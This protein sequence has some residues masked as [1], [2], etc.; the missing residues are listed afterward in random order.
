MADVEQFSIGSQ[1]QFSIGYQ[2]QFPLLQNACEDLEKSYSLGQ[3]LGEGQFGTTYLCTELATGLQYACKRIPKRKLISP[4]EIEDVG[5][6]VEVMCHL[7][8]DPNIVTLKGTYMDDD[9]VYLVMEL[10]EG[11]E[12]FDRII[13]RGTYTEAEAAHLTRTIV[14][15][16][17]TCH[18]SGVVHRDLKPENFLFKTKDNDS[19]LKAADFG[20]ARF[21]EPGDVF[22]EI[23][24]SPYYVA[25]EVLDRHYGPEVDIWSAGVMLYI[26][27]CGYPPYYSESI[28]GIFEKVMKAEP[29]S[30]SADPWPNISEGAKDL[31]RKMLNP[32]PKKRLKAHE[33]LKHPWIRED[34][35]AP[36]KPIASLVQFRMKQ[37][38]ALNK[39]K[40]LAIR[41][42]AETLSE[43]EIAN[44]KEIFTELDSDN[45][46]AINFEELKAGLLRAGTSLKE[47]EIFDLMEAADVDHDG[48]IDYGEFLAATLSLNHIEMEENLMAAFGI[49]DKNGS[50]HITTDELLAVCHEFH[51]ED[52]SLE[53][54]LHDVSI[55]ADG[56]ID[57]KM[58]VSMMRKGH[59]GMGHQN[60]RCTLGITDV[61]TLEEH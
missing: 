1:E 45:D 32:D 2:E 28:Q 60:L 24:G 11:G 19:V 25:P 27:L 8:G 51:M 7:S 59:G 56:S 54:L 23:V 41:I 16:V 31:I 48:M 49:L 43:E 39:V 17:E 61:M 40:K 10:C 18:K 26:F 22:T 34:G 13:E 57:Y 29:V 3:K 33:V 46:G 53:D 38:A 52:L 6:E 44:L 47:A 37:F 5:R 50:G 21:Y 35:V 4:E 15:V 14:R 20:S 12:L 42:I 58:F 55:E 30:F 9:A 36:C